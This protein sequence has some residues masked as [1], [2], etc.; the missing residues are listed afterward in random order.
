LYLCC[1]LGFWTAPTITVGHLVF[2]TLCT[3]YVFVGMQFEERGL[4]AIHGEYQRSVPAILPMPGRSPAAVTP[5]TPEI[6]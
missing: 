6:A 5:T 4:I 2:A 1:F 3:G